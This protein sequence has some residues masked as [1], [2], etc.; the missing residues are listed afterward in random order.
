VQQQNSLQKNEVRLMQQQTLSLIL[1]PL[2]RKNDIWLALKNLFRW[3][4]A[5][6]CDK[7]RAGESTNFTQLFRKSVQLCKHPLEQRNGFA[8][9]MQ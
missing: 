5:I 3:R 8:M 1:H 9:A 4:S 7:K 2:E 6:H